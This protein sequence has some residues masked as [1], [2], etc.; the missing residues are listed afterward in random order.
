MNGYLFVHFIGEQEMGE[1]IYF[2]VSRDG[3]HFQDLNGGRPVLVSSLGDQGVRDP[4]LARHP[5]TGMYH[6]IATDLCIF[7]RQSWDSACNKGSRAVIVWDSA[8]LIHWSAPRRVEIGADNAGCVWAP[9]AIWDEEREAFF[10]FFAS[11]VRLGSEKK[12]KQRIYGAYTADFVTFTAPNVYAEDEDH[13]IDMNIVRDD[14]WYYRFTKDET[15]KRIRMERMRALQDAP[16]E[17]MSSPLLSSLYGV[18]GPECYR[19]PDGRWCLIVDRFVKELGYLPLVTENLSTGD[20]TALSEKDFDLGR[21]KKRHG[22][23]LEVPL[24][25]LDR[26]IAAYGC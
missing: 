14:G 24:D 19:L 25:V 2:S 11:N 3:L 23:V 18:E 21:L 7:R 12:P 5:K 17:T 15:T 26:L 16:V 9:E 13:L 22:G 1:Q 4:F 8:D 10:V 6:L 20:F